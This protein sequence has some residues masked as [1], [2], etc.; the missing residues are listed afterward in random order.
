MGQ[1][2]VAGDLGSS[3]CQTKIVIL[4]V[5]STRDELDC[6]TLGPKHS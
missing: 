6:L 3:D 2:S 5:A 4:D 1:L